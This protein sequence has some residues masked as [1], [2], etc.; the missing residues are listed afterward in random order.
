MWVL[1]DK[2]EIMKCFLF[3]CGV[4]LANNLTEAEEIRKR[5]QEHTEELHKSSLNTPKSMMMCSLT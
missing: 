3:F 5:W 1:Q 2:A 4:F